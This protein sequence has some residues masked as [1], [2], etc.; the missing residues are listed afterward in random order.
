[1]VQ[2]ML[3]RFRKPGKR[4]ERCPILTRHPP[5]PCWNSLCH[6]MSKRRKVGLA[7]AKTV[8]FSKALITVVSDPNQ[9]YIQSH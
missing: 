7:L 8:A 2:V 6:G 1:M 4:E 9:S 3:Q 5:L